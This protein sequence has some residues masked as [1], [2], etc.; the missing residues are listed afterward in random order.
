MYYIILKVT[1]TELSSTLE[2]RR[3]FIINFAYYTILI[4]LFCLALA[5]A[6]QPMLPI[7]IAAFIAI[8]LQKPVNAISKKTKLPKGL[9]S[10]ISVLIL[11]ALIVLLMYFIGSRLFNELKDFIDFI[12]L[13]IEDY[14]WIESQIYYI[15]NKLPSYLKDSITP[16]VN[17]FLERLKPA[18]ESDAA[19][20]VYKIGFSAIKFP[21][22]KS[23]F[24]GVLN[25]A[26]QIP[27]IF[28]AVLVCVILSCFMTAEYDLFSNAIKKYVPGGENNIFSAIKRVLLTSVFKLFKAYFFIMC[29][30]FS[31]MLLGLS[32][33]KLIGIFDS[34]YIFAISLFAAVF[35]IMPILGIGGILWSWAIFEFAMGD[36][37]MGVALILLYIFITIVRQIIEPKLVAGQM[38]L[39]SSLTLA[40]MYI[41]L[42][43]FGVI[44]MFAFTIS[45]YCLKV[46]DSE[47][48]IHLFEGLNRAEHEISEEQHAE[49]TDKPR[50]EMKPEPV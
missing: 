20:G 25:T 40:V 11:I 30:T 4:I 31:E 2:K 14:A 10:A 42:K 26:M 39:P 16:T 45:L 8:I 15:V 44:G 46:L 17:D 13:K 1:V 6:F 47:G 5:Y 29:V 36:V 34:K 35:D 49:Q 32:L 50:E 33:F 48:V 19:S 18:M 22:I 28:I 9:I 41:G 7:I 12:R 24:P 3:S 43:M 21:S 23:I 27:S 37:A 38:S